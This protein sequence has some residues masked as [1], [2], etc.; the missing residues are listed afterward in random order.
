MLSRKEIKVVIWDVH[1]TTEQKMD[2]HGKRKRPTEEDAAGMCV[3][4]SPY[5]PLLWSISSISPEWGI[6]RNA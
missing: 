2:Q 6:Q 3:R 4:L 1:L 5:K